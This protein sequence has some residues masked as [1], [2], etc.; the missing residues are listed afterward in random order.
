M[1]VVIK[2]EEGVAFI[3]ADPYVQGLGPI[4]L[5]TGSEWV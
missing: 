1:Q 3:Y 5:W 2:G 4:I